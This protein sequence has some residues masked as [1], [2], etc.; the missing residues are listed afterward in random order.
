MSTPDQNPPTKTIIYW[1]KKHQCA[2][3]N[4]LVCAAAAYSKESCELDFWMGHTQLSPACAVE[5]PVEGRPHVN[6][7]ALEDAPHATQEKHKQNK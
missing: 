3:R 7:T 5:R 4:P 6:S 1:C 2:T